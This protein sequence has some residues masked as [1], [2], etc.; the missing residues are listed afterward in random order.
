MD[1]AIPSLNDFTT[2]RCS[3]NSLPSLC[4]KQKCA[5]PVTQEPE[6]L[7]KNATW[8]QKNIGTK[9]RVKYTI[10]TDTIQ[11]FAFYK[12]KQ[13]TPNENHQRKP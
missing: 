3:V 2:V 6:Q 12:K 7:F 11:K 5:I 4:L 8:K 10:Y 1:D 9:Q 13:Q